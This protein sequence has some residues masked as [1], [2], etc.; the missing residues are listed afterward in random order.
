MAKLNRAKL[1]ERAIKLVY[2]SLSSHLPYM[3][4]KTAEGK[5]FHKKC[6]K[7]YSELIKIL[8]ELL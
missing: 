2:S 6:T 5:A 3:Y 1:V 7:E 4:I 8:S